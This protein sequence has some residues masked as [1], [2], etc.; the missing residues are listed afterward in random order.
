MPHH[1]LQKPLQAFPSMLN[2]IVTES[3]C[4]DLARERRD[5]DA[6]TFPLEYITEVLEIR[7]PSAYGA[8]LEFEG[9][10]VRAA[11]DLVISI[12]VARGAMGLGIA[13][14]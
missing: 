12:H 9:G 8:M 13:D 2:H 5:R 10:N 4:E 3:V 11:D 6:G 1:N 7:I 14:L